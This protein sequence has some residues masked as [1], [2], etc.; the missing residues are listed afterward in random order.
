MNGSQCP[1]LIKRI[2]ESESASW[3]HKMSFIFVLPTTKIQYPSMNERDFVGAV[4]LVPYTKGPR[5]SL[6]Y[7]CI[8]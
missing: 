7:L 4:Y 2:K 6:T 8:G 1:I 5:R 3:Q